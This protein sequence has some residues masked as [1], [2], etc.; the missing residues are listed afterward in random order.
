MTGF[1]KRKGYKRTELKETILQA[2]SIRSDFSHGD[3]IKYLKDHTYQEMLELSKK[4]DAYTRFFMIYLLRHTE[5]DYDGSTDDISE[6][7]DY[8]K[9]FV[10][11]SN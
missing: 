7:R 6:V 11:I 10:E 5:L 9:S 4:M 1:A 2:Y 3:E 8:F